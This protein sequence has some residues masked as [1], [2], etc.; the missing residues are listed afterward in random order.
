MLKTCGTTT[1]LHALP[2]ILEMAAAIGLVE[3]ASLFYSRKAFLF[4][5]E[6]EF[7]H[8]RWDDEVSYLRIIPIKANID[9]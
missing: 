4:P 2:R 9:D 8:G 5:D 3:I 1:L 6:Q 7:P